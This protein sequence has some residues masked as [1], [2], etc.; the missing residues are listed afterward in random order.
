MTDSITQNTNQQNLANLQNN[1][2]S[3]TGEVVSAGQTGSDKLFSDFDD[4]LTLLTTQLQ[5]QDPLSPLETA[6]FT[7]QLVGFA[8]VE[9]QLAQTEQL[10][11][12]TALLS[13][14]SRSSAINHIGLNVEYEGDKFTL[15]GATADIGYILPKDTGRASLN[16]YDDDNDLVAT[17]QLSDIKPEERQDFTWDGY[18]E[19]DGSQA[20]TF[21]LLPGQNGAA[22]QAIFEYSLPQNT[23]SASLTIRDQDG[24]IVAT[25]NLNVADGRNSAAWDGKGTINGVEA[26]MPTGIYS[27]HIT[28]QP[29]SGGP[30][31]IGSTKV[32]EMMPAGNYRA[33]ISV[34]PTSGLQTVEGNVKYFS[35]TRV[36]GVNGQG[37]DILLELGTGKQIGANEIL[38]AKL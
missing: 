32:Y 30:N 10:K 22:P 31:L 36:I 6:E 38:Q 2:N 28:A 21:N 1:L 27:Y 15:E 9:Q 16:I 29:R 12:M 4:F 17:Y 25:R 20:R 8:G 19:A 13:A 37:E 11:S 5:Y 14:Q 34:N 3:G 33:E 18:R 23:D 26:P 24:T 7:N 35:T